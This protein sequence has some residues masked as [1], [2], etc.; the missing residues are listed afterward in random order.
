MQEVLNYTWPNGSGWGVLAQAWLVGPNRTCHT[1]PCGLC[2]HGMARPLH[3]NFLLYIFH[4]SLL[5]LYFPF[6]LDFFP[7]YPNFTCLIDL[8]RPRAIF[9]SILAWSI[10]FFFS[11]MPRS[12]RWACVAWPT[13]GVVL[14]TSRTVLSVWTFIF[15]IQLIICAGLHIYG[16]KRDTSSA[17]NLTFST[18]FCQT[19]KILA[20]NF[21]I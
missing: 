2:W 12:Q 13:I 11:A 8:F 18:R 16:E 9:G 3:Q 1:R 10:V 7:V 19:F 17:N 5:S 6:T 15:R 21:I 20:I 4:Y 14:L